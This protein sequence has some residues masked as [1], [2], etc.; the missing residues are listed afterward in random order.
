MLE[1]K[2]ITNGIS[3]QQDQVLRPCCTWKFDAEW[4][5]NNR[6]H[7]V[8][9]ANWHQ[10]ESVLS[11]KQLLDN[12]VWPDNC[13]SCSRREEAGNFGNMRSNG[14]SA[15]SDY[16]DE[17]ITLEIRPGNVCNL[18]C[19]TCWPE[20]SSRVAN[21]QYRAGLIDKRPV[22]TT[23]Q[24]FDFLEPIAHRIRDVVL[25]GGEPFYD[26]NCKK[27]L[28]WSQQNLNATQMIFTN[29]VVIDYN[30]LKNY[31]GK[32]ILIFSLDAVG[33]SAEYVRLGTDWNK[34]SENYARCKQLDNV[35]VRVN[36]TT[37]VYNYLYIKPLLEFLANDWP[38]LITISSV[39]DDH[40][41]I[42]TI[43]MQHRGKIVS[44]LIDAQEIIKKIEMPEHQAQHVSNA[45][46]VIIS[47]LNNAEFDHSS[48]LYLRR[49]I[50]SLDRVKNVKI[51]DYCPELVDILQIST[52]Q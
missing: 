51:E 27:F 13:K 36:V 26:K 48:H 32:I 30:F 24:S 38:D 20:A 1:C 49:Y 43:P 4:A 52:E 47:E 22:D 16:N 15:Y 33:K 7:E 29:G 41:R 45:I 9:I 37:S 34:V 17:D 46:K 11:K 12:N 2:F 14:N 5:K 40:L 8:D 28:E 23:I 6:A 50:K 25:L 10:S 18:A 39:D 3:V 21:Y 44:E 19:Q 31:S 42:K 35:E